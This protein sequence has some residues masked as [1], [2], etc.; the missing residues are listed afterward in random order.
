MSRMSHVVHTFDL[1]MEQ[2]SGYEFRVRFDKPH[3]PELTLDEPA[4]LG[5]DAAPN[6]SRVLAAAIGNC[7][8]ASLA[9]CMSRAGEPLS[10][11]RTTVSVELVR[12]EDKRLRIGKVG[13]V[14]HPKLS[15]GGAAFA[16]CLPAF[17]DFCVVTQSVRHGVEVDVRVEPE[18]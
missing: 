4:P 18:S 6:A 17:E 5:K 12:N 3:Y 13:V 8:S 14:L 16:K 7:L 9:F 1:E 10:G 15:P 11:I 2:V